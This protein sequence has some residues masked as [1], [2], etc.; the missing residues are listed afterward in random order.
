MQ[1]E[2]LTTQ[3]MSAASL[4]EQSSSQKKAKEPSGSATDA[5]AVTK[6]PLPP[7]MALHSSMTTAEILA[8]LNK[9][10]LFMTEL[11][12]NDDIAALQALDYEGSALENSA[13]FKERG[14]ECFKVR[15]YADARE[16]YA[17]GVALLAAEER[18][19]ACGETTRNPDDG[20]ADSPADVAAQ[21]ALLASLH[22][23]RAAPP[24][25]EDAAVRLVPDPD[26]PRSRLAF[27]ALLLYPLHF[28][29]DFVKAFEETQ[30]LEDHLGYVFPLP[31]DADAVYRLDSVSCYVETRDGGL[32]KMGKKASLLKVLS[33]GKVE[34]VD[35]VVRI[36]VLPADKA[37]EWIVKFKEQKA[38]E[39]GRS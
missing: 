17:K 25:M 8:D 36:F 22:L 26:D 30:S 39:K 1:L 2:E 13:G 15:G 24:E 28:E 32:L 23:N 37:D 7:G 18:K 9:S 21:R 5:A 34:V 19:R 3:L 11:E 31:W 38:K 12:D 14:N 27:P 29:T 4:Q 20:V 10:P 16:F 33:T 6:P 35:Q